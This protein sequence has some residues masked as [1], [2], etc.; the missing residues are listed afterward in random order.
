M[1]HVAL[2]RVRRVIGDLRR[3]YFPPEYEEKW[4]KPARNTLDEIAAHYRKSRA[5]RKFAR[6]LRGSD[7]F[8][9]GHPKSGNTWT[10][11]II[12]LLLAEDF[13]HSVNLANVG[14]FVP[15]IH[16]KD[17]EIAEYPDLPNPRVF[18]NEWPVFPELYPRVICLIRDPRAILVSYYHM[19][20]TIT[21]DGATSISDFVA[22]YLEKGCV[23]RL[24]PNLRWDVHVNTWL[25]RSAQDDTV[26]TMT[27]EQMLADRRSAIVKLARF[28][29]VEASDKLIE[30]TESRSSFSSM[31][32][33]ENQHGAESYLGLKSQKSAFIRK[34]KAEGWR[35]EL[36]ED[37]VRAIEAVLGKT[38][39]RA[40]YSLE[41]ER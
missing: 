37:D 3:P 25:D 7:V 34:G 36:P 35:E 20:K 16:G 8:V 21:N 12:G 18:R 1:S 14:E 9:V 11:Y 2:Q 13:E 38:M 26:M 15:V 5:R 32:A 23:I 27:Y 29:G 41:Y 24:E 40:G 17:C 6:D 28:I 39:L 30:M 22:E 10:A 19:F 33:D 31:K 4:G